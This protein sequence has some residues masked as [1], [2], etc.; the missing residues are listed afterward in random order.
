MNEKQKKV[1]T[2]VAIVALVLIPVFAACETSSG[3]DLPPVY[4]G[5]TWTPTPTPVGYVS[6][7]KAEQ[8]TFLL[9]VN[10]EYKLPNDWEEK[11]DLVETTNCL[12]EE[13]KVERHALAAFNRL[14]EELLTQ[15]VQIELDSTYRSVQEQIEMIEWMN[16]EYGPGYA[17]QYA[18]V[19]GYS[20]HH[21]GLALD[22]FLMK[23]GKEVRDNNEMLAAAEDFYK[24]H[25]LLTKYG[26]ILRYP[27]GKQ[28]ITGY[29]YEP[30]HIRYIGSKS[31]AEAITEA[32][33]L[34]EYLEKNPS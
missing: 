32:G 12:G 26:F 7:N 8:S 17:E 31:I 22:I 4:N 19:P 5:P 1:L 30:W 13:L 10:K 20:E 6:G 34:E 14:R 24:V 27:L 23:D 16:E 21:T 9:L 15:G 29:S 2:G 28:D 18:A 11:V 33:T 25:Q 3:K